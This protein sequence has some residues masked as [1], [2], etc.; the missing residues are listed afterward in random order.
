MSRSAQEKEWGRER[1]QLRK[2][3]A[4]QQYKALLVDHVSQC[5]PFL[6]GCVLLGVVC[7]QRCEGLMCS[8]MK[9]NVA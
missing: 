6:R 8:G 9:P 4:Q 3:E 5:L 2:N 1:D 7:L